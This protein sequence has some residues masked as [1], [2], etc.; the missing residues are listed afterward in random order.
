MEITTENTQKK[1]FRS[2]HH[3]Y[4]PVFT[5]ETDFINDDIMNELK[6][7][8]EPFYSKLEPAKIYDF[9]DKSE[10][11]SEIRNLL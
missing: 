4:V 9:H 1:E 3:G 10:I 7:K 8:L 6:S 11:I 5:N 2:I